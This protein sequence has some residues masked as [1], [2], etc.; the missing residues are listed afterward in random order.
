MHDVRHD[1]NG[2]IP[3]VEPVFPRVPPA[4]VPAQSAR[5]TPFLLA[6][7][8]ILGLLL[9][10][11]GLAW[12][13]PE[14]TNLYP[15][16]HDH[17]L[18][19]ALAL[20]WANPEP[21]F[22]N[23]PTFLCNSIALLHGAAKWL[24][25]GRP[26][27]K[28]YVIGRGISAVSGVLSILAVFFLA[29]RFG[30]A[31][32]ALLAA[33][34]MALLP[35]N[36]W[37]SHVAVTDVLMNFWILMAL[38]MSVLL[39]EEPRLRHAVLAGVCTGLAA[40][41]KYTGGLVC[42]APFVSLC[43][44]AGLSWKRRAGFLLLA[45]ACALLAAFVATPY[46]FIRMGN[47][48][49][50]LAFENRHT[51]G[52]QLGFSLPAAGWQYHKFLYQL[53]AAGP[54]SLGLPL[55]LAALVGAAWFTF[56]PDRR[57]WTLLVFASA[58]TLQT[59]TLTFT[60]IRYYHPLF[61]LGALC[62]GLWLGA[63]LEH[64][65]AAFRRRAAAAVVLLVLA[66]T[67]AF[68]ISTTRRYKYDTRIA[69]DQWLKTHLQ[70]GQVVHAFGWSPYVAVVQNRGFP[71]KVHPEGHLSTLDHLGTNDLIEVTSMHYLRWERHG[72]VGLAG[73]Y[74]RL[75]QTPEHFERLAVFDSPYLGREFYGRL[76]PMFRGYF[77]SPTIEFYRPLQPPPAP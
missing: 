44:A 19:H 33:L 3:V 17:V 40:G 34:W 20:S 12:G 31:A 24:D 63:E 18:Q 11:W 22:L 51:H 16:E 65:G 74:H 58:W 4:D 23:Y 14:R 42:L 49:A 21:Q 27:W 75:R 36:V 50:A 37:D 35:V 64:P 52:F 6:G 5:L 41:A 26:D 55:Y 1:F 43:L 7:I 76:D 71:E 70:P 66:A 69:A 72:H 62:A 53:V 39:Q 15:D 2:N 28:A 8:V 47:T 54:F 46:S 32:G 61:S 59:C 48:L 25:P 77:I 67:L 38:W 13:L 73:L 10:F 30:G 60:P 56:R 29:R 68:T 57:R 9:R 45:A